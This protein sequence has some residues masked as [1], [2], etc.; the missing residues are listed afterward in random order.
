MNVWRR[1]EKRADIQKE[2]KQLNTP[3][4]MEERAVNVEEIRLPWKHSV[5]KEN[6]LGRSTMLESSCQ[7]KLGKNK[8]SESRTM[9]F[10]KQRRAGR[11]GHMQGC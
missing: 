1:K 9:N 8:K 4:K 10:N 2:L 7:S 3:A 5:Y 11:L 6:L